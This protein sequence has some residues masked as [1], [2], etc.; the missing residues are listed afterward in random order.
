MENHHAEVILSA[1]SL[2]SPQLLLKS[3]IGAA[4]RLEEVGLRCQH[5]L[6]GV[7]ENLQDHLQLRRAGALRL[8]DGDFRLTDGMGRDFWAGFSGNCSFSG[9]LESLESL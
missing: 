8:L 9:C 1:G 4:Q 6:P 5:D 3:G 7:G 2:G